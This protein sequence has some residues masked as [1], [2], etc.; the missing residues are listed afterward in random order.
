MMQVGIG[1][2]QK[3]IAM[4]T[5]L[6]QALQIIDKRKKECVAVVYPTKEHSIV[7]KLAGKYR[8]QI[9]S[10]KLEEAKAEAMNLAMEEKFGRHH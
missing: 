7:A 9:R 6:D 10:D 3:N 8:D 4:L 2:I 1:E 5:S